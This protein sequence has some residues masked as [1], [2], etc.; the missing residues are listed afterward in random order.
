MLPLLEGFAE[1]KEAR[2]GEEEES[3]QL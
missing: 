2:I 3:K 1:R